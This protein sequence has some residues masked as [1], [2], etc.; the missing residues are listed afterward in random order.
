MILSFV[1]ALV[2]AFKAG[3]E[4]ALENVALRQQ[5]AVLRRSVKRPRLSNVDRE[6]WVLWRR[7]WI[8]WESVLRPI[9]G[10]A[11][12]IIMQTTWC[13]STFSLCRPQ[14]SEFCSS[15]SS[16]AT[17]IAVSFISMSPNILLP[18]GRRSKWSMLFHGTRRL[19]TWYGIETRPTERTSI[20]ASTVSG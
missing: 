18:S 7:I 10:G 13:R 19:G 6:F 15:S 16:F 14:P 8:D 1:R 2:S 11:F 5:L 12:S 3:R 17:T 9:L 4:L 20:L